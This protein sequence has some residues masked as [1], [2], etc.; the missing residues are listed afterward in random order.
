MRLCLGN[1]FG[2]AKTIEYNGRS[3]RCQ[4]TRNAEPDPA[5]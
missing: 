2:L 4:G 3:G 1:R 5:G